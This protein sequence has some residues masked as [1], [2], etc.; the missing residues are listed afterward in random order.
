MA[1]CCS[2]VLPYSCP[3]SYMYMGFPV[4]GVGVYLACMRASSLVALVLCLLAIYPL[5][6]NL[7]TQRWSGSYTLII[8]QVGQ[9]ALHLRRAHTSPQRSRVRCRLH[10]ARTLQVLPS[11]GRQRPPPKLI[12]LLSSHLFNVPAPPPTLTL[13]T[14][15]QPRCAACCRPMPQRAPRAG[16]WTPG[17][18]RRVPGVTAPAACTAAGLSARGRV[19][20]AARKARHPAPARG[21]SCWERGRGCALR[22]CPA[23]RAAGG[24]LAPAA[25]ARAVSL[26]SSRQLWGR[27]P[28]SARASSGCSSWGRW[29][30]W[31]GCCCS[32]TCRCAAC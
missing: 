27:I 24:R 22:I 3:W 29:P 28:A 32:C 26:G 15:H 2:C 4:A 9:V 1:Q 25:L 23:R 10:A 20:T 7:T 6:D 18:W 31:C 16:A 11:R 17:S 5:A 13:T 21:S 14:N 8:D 12:H 19:G 30:S